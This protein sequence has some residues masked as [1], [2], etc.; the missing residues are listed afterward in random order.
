MRAN[1]IAIVTDIIRELGSGTAD[2][3]LPECEGFTRDQVMQA[4][5]NAKH[6]GY[7]ASEGRQP[8][9]KGRKAAGLMIYCIAPEPERAPPAN[10]VWQFAERMGA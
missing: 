4:L 9:P 5:Q 10:S 2:D 6:N 8:K 1:L 7:L 3:V